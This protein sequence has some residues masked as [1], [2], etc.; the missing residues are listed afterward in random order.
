MLAD[1]AR[2]ALG[3][4]VLAQPSGR[5]ADRVYRGA[6]AVMVRARLERLMQ[7]RAGR[8]ELADPR[9]RALYD[10]RTELLRPQAFQL[11]LNEHWSAAER[12]GHEL[13]LVTRSPV[14]VDHSTA[15]GSRPRS[16]RP[17][18]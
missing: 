12:H 18:P 13:A 8:E 1:P 17:T 10:D 7:E 9:H 14:S 4:A 11:R 3:L 5:V 16:M 15:R 6:S 2:A